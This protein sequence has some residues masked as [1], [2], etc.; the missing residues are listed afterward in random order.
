MLYER[1]KELSAVCGPRV[2]RQRPKPS[3][4]ANKYHWLLGSIYSCTIPFFHTVSAAMQNPK[5][6]GSRCSDSLQHY[7]HIVLIHR[8]LLWLIRENHILS[9]T[10]PR[11]ECVSLSGKHRVHRKS[12]AR[13][14]AMFPTKGSQ[15]P[16]LGT[17]V[18]QQRDQ[19]SPLSC[20]LLAESHP[21]TFRC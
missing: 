5:V 14:R 1:S 16:V 11:L 8:R 18:Q 9:D 13:Y 19:R 21:R 10:C 3:C 15:E 2:E 12:L 7:R 4:S 17:R 6:A 20:C